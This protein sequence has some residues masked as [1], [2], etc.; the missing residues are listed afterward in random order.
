MLQSILRLMSLL[1]VTLFFSS[2]VYGQE[3][4]R[5]EIERIVKN[6]DASAGVGIRHLE[7]SDT[8]SVHGD[9]HFPMQS[10]YKFHLALA[11]LA[12]VDKGGLTVDK[13][14]LIEKKDLQPNTWS[15][16]AKKYPEGNVELTIKE[17][18]SY[19][20]SQSDNN[21]CDI[22]FRMVGGPLK[23]Q[24]YIHG[25][26]IK[27]VAILNTEEEMHTEWDMQF[28]NWTTPKAMTSLLDLFYMKKILSPQSSALLM[29]IMEQTVTGNK[30][31]KG[32]LP[33]EIV[34]GHKTGMSGTDNGYLGAIN[35]VGVIALPNG[36]HLA[37]AFFI[38]K[39]R[40][41]VEKLESA[42][43]QISKLAFDYYTKNKH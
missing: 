10:V 31:I 26:G 21:G 3:Q 8:L 23:V 24:S 36:D 40:E 42:M 41:N 27:D 39:T 38:S 16:I 4:L 13:K 1:F 43:A 37:V 5:P 14:I 17:L 7:K 11:V 12:Q 9:R 19:T 30:R 32:L 34:V 28:R 29:E 6:L 18:L 2:G 25:L 15:P 20:V 35:D 33:Q 22:L